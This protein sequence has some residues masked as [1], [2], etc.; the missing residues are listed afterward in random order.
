MKQLRDLSTALLLALAM[1]AQADQEQAPV[2]TGRYPAAMVE[3]PTLAEHTIY[4]PQDLRRFG[5]SARLPLLLWGNG[6]CANTGNLARAFL[7]ELASHGYLVISSGPV[8]TLPVPRSATPGGDALSKTSQLFDAI[9]WATTENQRRGGDYY[10]RIDLSKVAVMGTSC[11]GLQALEAAVDPRIGTAIIWSS[12]LLDQPRA[13]AAAT[14][15]D[16]AR[17]HGPILFVSGGSNDMASPFSARDY[18]DINGVPVMLAVNEGAGHG[19]TLNEPNGGR[20]ATVG[21]AWLDWQLK[22]DQRVAQRFVGK[23]CGLCKD[24]AWAVS[25]KKIS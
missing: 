18:G 7:T 8:R 20:W 3:A 10:G 6:G 14:R 23:E 16:L 11:G 17:L 24:A 5:R 19:G 2:G 9:A 22:H 15:A 21:L 13:G 1:V 12:G 25:R 4:R